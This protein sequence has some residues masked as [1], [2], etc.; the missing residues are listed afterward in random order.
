MPHSKVDVKDARPV[1]LKILFS[2]DPM[3]DQ[4]I[5]RKILCVADS[6]SDQKI[7]RK[8]ASC[9]KNLIDLDGIVLYRAYPDE[10]DLD[11]QACLALLDSSSG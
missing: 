3:I 8:L 10:I 9:E 7:D 11:L 2:A 5:L 6:M 1:V 4:R